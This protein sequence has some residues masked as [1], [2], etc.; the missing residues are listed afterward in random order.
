[1]NYLASQN[2]VLDLTYPKT[3]V[4]NSGG[5][6]VWS[7]TIK[8]TGGKLPVKITVTGY[9]SDTKGNTYGIN[10]GEITR[11]WEKKLMAGQ[12]LSNQYWCEGEDFNN[13][14]A[15]FKWKVEDAG[16]HYYVLEENVL[17]ADK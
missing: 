6:W 15:Y 13:G 10:G 16:G 5:R 17:L 2:A 4:K 3:V 12:S 1:M 7:S 11:I 14:H 8:E 9:I